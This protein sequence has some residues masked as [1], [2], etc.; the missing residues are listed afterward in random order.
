MVKYGAAGLP[1]HPIAADFVRLD[2]LER[3]KKD[4]P[5]R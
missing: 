4:A 5:A 2:L 3:A 1:S